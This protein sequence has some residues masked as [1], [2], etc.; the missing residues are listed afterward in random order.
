MRLLRALSRAITALEELC[1]A[2]GILGIAALTISNVLMRSLT[3]E[4]L[5]FSEEASRFLIVLVTFL[6][7]GYAAGQGR[8]IRMTAFYD[9]LGDRS[10]K[11]VM[12]VVSGATALLLAWLS[13]LAFDYVFGTVRELGAV[14]PV[15]QIPKWIIYLAA[16]IG[17]TLGAVQFGLA[18]VRNLTTPGVWISFTLEDVYEEPPEV[19]DSAGRGAGE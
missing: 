8:H 1:L 18:F 7:I 3:G 6:G 9:A 10:R 5:L 11:G 16:P 19:P 14:S 17:L 13:W 4:S 2:G 12:L 15:L